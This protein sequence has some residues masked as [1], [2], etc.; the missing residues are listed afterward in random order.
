MPVRIERVDVATGNAVPWSE[1]APA[2]RTGMISV[3]SVLISDDESTISY[4]VRRLLSEL[5]VVD[6]LK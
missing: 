2:D 4:T 3:A 6:G 1:I 5:Y